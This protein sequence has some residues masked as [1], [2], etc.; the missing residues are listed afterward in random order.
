VLELDRWPYRA[1]VPVCVVS[2]VSLCTGMLVIVGVMLPYAVLI[3]WL[4]P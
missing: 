2:I 4:D 1:A 3:A